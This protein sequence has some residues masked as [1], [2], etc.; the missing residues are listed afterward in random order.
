MLFFFNLRNRAY[1]HS[2]SHFKANRIS[3][4]R[5]PGYRSVSTH[6]DYMYKEVYKKESTT[7]G[8]ILSRIFSNT[9]EFCVANS[10]S[11]K[12]FMQG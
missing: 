11:Y 3:M 9:L 10:R 1:N 8:Q 12:D 4:S 6:G 7:D 5:I 2:I